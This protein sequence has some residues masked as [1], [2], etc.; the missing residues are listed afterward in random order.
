MSEESTESTAE[1]P[2]YPMPRAA[3]CPFAPAPGVRE[4]AT[5]GPIYTVR[6]WEGK[7]AWLITGYPEARALLSNS[8]VHLD[9]LHPEFPHSNESMKALAAMS[10]RTMFNTEGAEHARFRRMLAKPFTPKR[11]ETLRPLIQKHV[12]ECIDTMLAAGDSAD[13]HTALALPV[14]SLVICELL[15]VPYE[16]HAFFQHH[17][18]VGMDSNTTADQAMQNTVEMLNYLNKLIEVKA[19]K[20]GEDLLTDMAELVRSGELQS[21]EAGLQAVGFLAAGHETTANMIGL[22]VLALLERP[23]QLALI[24]DTDDPKLLLNAIDELCRYMAIPHIG[25]R[26][27]A[28]EDI[29]IAGETIHAG[30]PLIVDIPTANRDPNTFA[31]PDRIDGQR[32][33]AGLHL[34]FGAGRHNCI[35]LQLAR[36]ELAITLQTLFRRVPG[37][38]LATTIDRIGF[39]E[40]AMVYGLTTLPVAW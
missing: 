5:A 17:T 13:L 36:I 37:L 31:D 39:K 29:E 35:G 19:A 8:A 30:D 12:D 1:V 32:P 7:Q 21:W 38:R 16:D 20:P 9:N 18:E 2:F 40:E 24:R 11:L 27:V 4:I 26:R 23:D 22:S 10:P 34:S 3:G 25:L 33:T 28:V 15:G 6:T 14:P